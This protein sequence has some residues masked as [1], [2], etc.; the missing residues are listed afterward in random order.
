MVDERQTFI[1]NRRGDQIGARV[2][3]LRVIRPEHGSSFPE[4]PKYSHT[5]CPSCFGESV[6]KDPSKWTR[7]GRSVR[8]RVRR[9]IERDDLLRD[10]ETEG[11]S[12][13]SR[14]KNSLFRAIE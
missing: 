6:V 8:E 2:R 11:N 1:R 7:K 10:L 5:T 14:F 3:V 4:D 9:I 12:A 13:L